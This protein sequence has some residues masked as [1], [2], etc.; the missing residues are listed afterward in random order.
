MSR[1]ALRPR[2]DV[3]HLCEYITSRQSRPLSL[4]HQPFRKST[5]S[6]R[7]FTTSRTLPNKSQ[8]TQPGS[9]I[10][11]VLSG[12]SGRTGEFTEAQLE[13]RLQNVKTTCNTLLMQENI[14]SEQDIL[15]ALAGCSTMANL[16]VSDQK[17]AS[18][19]DGATSALLSLDEPNAKKIPV[20]KLPPVLQR[21]AD[22]VSTL[23]YSIIKFPPV[24]I[25]PEVL[26]LYVAIQS[27]LGKP[28]TFPEVLHLY[29]NK[30]FP[31]EGS[32]PITYSN[33]N[34]NKSSN[35]IPL[36]V[37]DQAL[38]TAVDAKQLVVAMEIIEA[39]YT[40]KAARRAKFI[41]KG[42]L[43][44]TGLAVAPIAAYTVAS[45][46]ALLQT[47]MDT[48]MATNVAFAGIIAYIGFTATVGIVA[49]TTANDQMDRVTWAQGVPLRQRWMREEERFAIDKVAGAWGFREVW[50]RGEEEG[51]DWEALREWIGR[52]SMMLDR[53]E[54][55]EGM[56]L[57]SIFFE[58]DI[59]TKYN[60]L[61]NT[62]HIV[63]TCLVPT[64]DNT[65][66]RKSFP[67]ASSTLFHSIVL[68]PKFKGDKGRIMDPAPPIDPVLANGLNNCHKFAR[69]L[70]KL[71]LG[72]AHALF[73]LA[74][75]FQVILLGITVM[76]HNWVAQKYAEIIASE[77]A[78]PDDPGELKRLKGEVSQISKRCL[79]GT[80]F[81]C[82]LVA[83]STVFQVFAA[84]NLLFCQDMPLMHFYFPILTIFAFGVL[85][86]TIGCAIV[87]LYALWTLTLP[88]FTVALGSPVLIVGAITHCVVSLILTFCCGRE[89][90][91]EHAEAGLRPSLTNTIV[92]VPSTNTNSSQTNI[93]APTASSANW[94][95]AQP[96]PGEQRLSTG[97][98]T[99]GT[100]SQGN[101]T[102]EHVPPP[103]TA[104]GES[105]RRPVTGEIAEAS[106]PN[107][108]TSGEPSG[109][110]DNIRL[111]CMTTEERNC[112]GCSKPLGKGQAAGT[113]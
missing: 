57:T 44:A 28:G 54:L 2:A 71:R 78:S 62:F 49:V 109:E 40:T 61:R 73:W 91:K 30:P 85:F 11:K 69:F 27:T 10:P 95:V 23:A 102:V 81:L 13:K 99:A 4:L 103:S 50:R 7:A 110:E 26:G 25:S 5:T 29:A 21:L 35:A 46:L 39:S 52:K 20:H 108:T 64:S 92:I 37:A 18:K 59:T 67:T 12:S 3:C 66:A 47:T 41:R 88:A 79:W 9:S 24:F 32:N 82:F 8:K 113:R 36:K 83:T 22:Q 100:T 19:K 75:V 38:Q 55:M 14:P 87:Q 15:E 63:I 60:A 86:A 77:L 93:L 68:M 45:Q 48:A 84:H 53:V 98:N 34:P 72:E 42:L 89:K 76:L 90:R 74:M 106:S 16:L 80:G 17:N 104:N 97:A 58:I 1:R 105:S 96:E 43:P 101:Q 51:E 94:S 112:P 111:Q 107:E 56:E 6:S 33:P 31:N 70:H 65:Q